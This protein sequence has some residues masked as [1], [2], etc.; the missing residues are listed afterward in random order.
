MNS[1]LINR[2]TIWPSLQTAATWHIHNKYSIYGNVFILD[3]ET[4]ETRELNHIKLL[5]AWPGV[6]TVRRWRSS[7]T[8]TRNNVQ[9]IEVKTG[10]TL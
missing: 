5:L 4:G 10:D 8:Q 3:T 9:V 2:S 7:T 1:L 6:Q